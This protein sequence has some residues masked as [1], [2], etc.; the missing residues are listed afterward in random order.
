MSTFRFGAKLDPSWQLKAGWIQRFKR[1][2]GLTTKRVCGE[3]LDAAIEDAEQWL[4]NEWPK[5]LEKYKPEDIYNADETSL[6]YQQLP[7][8]AIAFR[9][10]K[11]RGPKCSKKRVTLLLVVNMD[12][13]HRIKPIIVNNAL[14]PT[15]LASKYKMEYH[16]L[17][18][19]WYASKSAWVNTPIFHEVLKRLNRLFIRQNRKVCIIID[20]APC[21]FTGKTY[22]NV[23]VKF[24]PRR[25]TAVIQP[26]D[27][28]I[29]RSV[30]MKYRSSMTAKYL[31]ALEGRKPFKS[32]LVFDVKVACDTVARAWKQVTDETIKN[33]F[34]HAKWLASPETNSEA[35][36]PTTSNNCVQIDEEDQEVWAQF[37]RT[38]TDPNVRR[39]TLEEF[40]GH[41]DDVPVEEPISDEEIVSKIIRDAVA[42]VPET[43][44]ADEEEDRKAAEGNAEQDLVCDKVVTFADLYEYLHQVRAFANRKNLPLDHLDAFEDE[45]TRLQFS[46]STK[47]KTITDYLNDS[48]SAA[49]TTIEISEDEKEQEEEGEEQDDLMTQDIMAERSSPPKLLKRKGSAN[50]DLRRLVLTPKRN[51][52]QTEVD[53]AE[54]HSKSKQENL[55]KIPMESEEDRST[56]TPTCTGQENVTTDSSSPSPCSSLST[57][58][59]FSSTPS[60]SGSEEETPAKSKKLSP[61]PLTPQAK[62]ALRVKPRANLSYQ[63]DSQG[64][65]M[66]KPLTP[67]GGSSSDDWVDVNAFDDSNAF[68]DGFQVLGDEGEENHHEKDPEETEP[69]DEEIEDHQEKDPEET[70]ELH[71]QLEDEISTDGYSETSSPIL[72]LSSTRRSPPLGVRSLSACSDLSLNDSSHS[73]SLLDPRT[74]TQKSPGSLGTTIYSSDSPRS[75]SSTPPS[76]NSFINDTPEDYPSPSSSI[77]SMTSTPTRGSKPFDATLSPVKSG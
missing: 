58:S 22:S 20:N 49:E 61:Q 68:E 19:W 37:Q 3:Y 51:P 27:Q 66:V 50:E 14:R 75:L 10:E 57:L 55:R 40:A 8:K 43:D 74:S 53:K 18:V 54:V 44:E 9:G 36:L 71:L 4:A 6:F 72:E 13:S 26:L 25:T 35:N 15:C 42:Q 64:N 63:F 65:T 46:N 30:K 29:I 17:P 45:C 73:L 39:M 33:C 56:G 60:N 52:R 59:A 23:E 16:Q 24:L 1:K 31:T 34:R 47:Q 5:I 21:H 67:D 11:V 32:N 28:G 41:D 77:T 7:D 69:R 70:G 48:F 38:Q 12:A 2:Y 76:H 62:K